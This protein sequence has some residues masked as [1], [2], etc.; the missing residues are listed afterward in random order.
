VFF[1]QQL[2]LL[3]QVQRVARHFLLFS[4]SFD[5]IVVGLLVFLRLSCCYSGCCGSGRG[6]GGRYIQGAKPPKGTQQQPTPRGRRPQLLPGGYDNNS[7][8]LVGFRRMNC[9]VTFNGK[10]QKLLMLSR[11]RKIKNSTDIITVWA[12]HGGGAHQ[13]GGGMTPPLKMMKFTT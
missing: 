4:L 11:N 1:G 2:Q 13:G 7:I 5:G 3:V 10:S 9:Q 6:T 12:C 8:Y